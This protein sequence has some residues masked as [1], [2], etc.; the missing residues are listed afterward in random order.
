M[1]S[2]LKR[3]VVQKWLLYFGLLCVVVYLVLV[4]IFR[5]SHDRVWELGQENLPQITIDAN[6]EIV[7]NNFRNFDW[8]KDGVTK[9]RYETRTYSLDALESV[10][11]LISHFAEFEG[12][13]HI[14]LSFGFRDGEHVVVSFETRREIGEKFSPALG[15]LRQF[16][17]IYVV[18]SE[19][20]LVGVRT[21]VRENE[22]VYLYP[23][24]ASPEKAKE[25]FLALT[26]DINAVYS[27]PRIY[28]TLFS[29]CT[30]E[31][32]DRVEDISDIN[33]PLTWKTVLPGYFD[34]VLYEMGLIQADLPFSEVKKRHLIDNEAVDRYQATY[35][36]DLRKNFE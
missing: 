10:D 5:P 4:A 29:N 3:H 7:I 22:R 35:S 33:F 11:V 25:L 8:Q 26:E 24:V 1:K 32:T 31:I 14:F 23:T 19:E 13:A 12:L 16:E 21:D 34:E 6:N 36:N 2:Y 18:G 27:K 17:V 9:P 28:N 20:D 15:M 30:N